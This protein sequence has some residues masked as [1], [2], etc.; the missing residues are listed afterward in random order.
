[1]LASNTM[2]T[3]NP[4]T[5][6]VKLSRH[7]GDML[8]DVTC[9]KSPCPCSEDAN[10]NIAAA[11]VTTDATSAVFRAGAPSMI[12]AAAVIGQKMT[13]K[14]IRENHEIEMTND[15]GMTKHD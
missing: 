14:T 1:M 2:T 3:L 7:S 9:W 8:K 4:S 6:V 5:P 10:R 15:A 12:K 11:N 13:N